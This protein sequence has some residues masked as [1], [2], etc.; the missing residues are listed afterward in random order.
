MS[1]THFEADNNH[2]NSMQY[3][4]FQLK[5][6]LISD[7]KQRIFNYL[8]WLTS[9]LISGAQSQ[10][11][12]GAQHIFIMKPSSGSRADDECYRVLS[13]WP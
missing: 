9:L 13:A 11:H 3:Q 6:L 5:Q 2:P 4:A 7:N 1:Q 8:K 12:M 10:V